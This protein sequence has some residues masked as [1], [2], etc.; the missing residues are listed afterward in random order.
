MEYRLH[1]A[2]FTLSTCSLLNK[3]NTLRAENFFAPKAVFCQK[4]GAKK[5][6]EAPWPVFG[7]CLSLP[8][9]LAEVD[10]VDRTEKSIGVKSILPKN[11]KIYRRGVDLVDRIER[12]I[13][14]KSI[15]S[16]DMENLST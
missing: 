7:A 8:S 2:F 13:D 1:D 6:T 15:M 10:L 9:A 14:L 12:S 4:L 3:A 5:T 11:W 16:I